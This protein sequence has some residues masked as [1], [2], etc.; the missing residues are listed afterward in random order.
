MY[1]DSLV[2][3]YNVFVWKAMRERKTRR[4]SAFEYWQNNLFIL[5]I[6]W[7]FPVCLIALLPTTIMEIRDGGYDVAWINMIALAT[8]YI[9]A[10]Q[11]RIS[12]HWRKIFVAVI[13]VLFSLS[14]TYLL[15]TLELGGI[16]LF[17]LSIFMG[18]L[19]R[20]KL[21]YAGI[22][23]NALV[24]LVFTCTVWWKPDI[25]NLYHITFQRW[26]IYASNFLFIN[27]VVVVMVRILL[28]S[29]EKSLKA[30]TKLNKQLRIEMLLKQ[31]QH[32]RLR[33][34]AYIQS[35][36]VRA[37]LS[38]IKG[39]STLI[40]NIHGNHVEEL[41]LQSL[42]KSVNELDNVIKSVVDRTC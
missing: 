35:H 6:T 40:R 30:Q 23:V 8:I 19:F 11:Q 9:L 2:R 16:Y 39:L 21:S 14:L 22:M 25:I 24:I 4:H 17:S 42:D 32:R 33:E 28:V 41:L 13:L 27:F 15:H 20:G 31:D 5:I 10:I 38:N 34:I 36:L 37:P 1:L 3:H 12:F 7:I 26:V 29:V 18:L